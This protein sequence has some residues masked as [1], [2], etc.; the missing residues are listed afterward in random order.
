M[1]KTL[2]DIVGNP[3]SVKTEGEG[4][5]LTIL[6]KQFDALAKS[7]ESHPEGAPYTQEDVTKFN[8]LFGAYQ[9]AY[10]KLKAEGLIDK[11]GEL[12]TMAVKVFRAPAK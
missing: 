11:A 7:I 3:G 2:G 12:E 8:T 5:P 10:A 6:G 9:A 4:N 1:T